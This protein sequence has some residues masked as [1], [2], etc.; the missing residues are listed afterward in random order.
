MKTNYIYFEY[1]Q[2]SIP[3]IEV[4]KTI[5]NENYLVNMPHTNSNGVWSF[6]HW[7]ETYQRK[8]IVDQY[9]IDTTKYNGD[10]FY[11]DMISE[12]IKKLTLDTTN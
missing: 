2:L 8:L 9:W 4:R 12:V 6:R 7:T 10:G 5:T 3:N 1:H 11:E